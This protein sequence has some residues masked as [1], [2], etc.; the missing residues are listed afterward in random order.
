MPTSDEGMPERAA[1]VSKSEFA[2]A[3]SASTTDD[4]SVVSAAANGAPSEPAIRV[5]LPRQVEVR[6]VAD[7]INVQTLIAVTKLAQAL[8]LQIFE[9]DAPSLF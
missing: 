5:S 8:A 7:E 3:I 2:E 6:S 1:S 4:R 9:V